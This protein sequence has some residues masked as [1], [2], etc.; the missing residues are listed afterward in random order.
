MNW[1]YLNCGWASALKPKIIIIGYKIPI[2]VLNI[3]M[4]I[5][6]QCV[7][8]LLLDW[9]LMSLFCFWNHNPVII[10]AYPVDFFYLV[11]SLIPTSSKLSR[12]TRPK[13]A[14]YRVC[15]VSNK[16]NNKLSTGSVQYQTIS[17]INSVPG[18]CRYGNKKINNLKM[19]N[20]LRKCYSGEAPSTSPVETL[21]SL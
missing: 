21:L 16:L 10:V 11:N 13:D 3:T 17:T 2:I 8:F 19:L 12:S 5:H 18:L 15:A 1:I 4:N 9:L 20:F 14:Q 6:V 7:P